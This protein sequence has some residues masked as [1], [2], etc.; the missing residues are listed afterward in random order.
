[1]NLMLLIVFLLLQAI[2]LRISGNKSRVAKNAGYRGRNNGTRPV[3]EEDENA[4]VVKDG[5]GTYDWS[6]QVEEEATDFAL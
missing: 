5:L 4:L 1:M 6:Y 2:V 3:I